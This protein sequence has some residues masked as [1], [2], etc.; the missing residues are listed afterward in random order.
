MRAG[1]RGRWGREEDSSECDKNVL[2]RMD[3]GISRSWL[4]FALSVSERSTP[5]SH[6]GSEHELP[7]QSLNSRHDL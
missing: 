5:F 7:I 6:N 3:R 2:P 4:D 1:G